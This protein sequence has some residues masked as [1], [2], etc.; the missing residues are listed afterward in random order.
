MLVLGDGVTRRRQMWSHSR[1]LLSVTHRHEVTGVGVTLSSDWRRGPELEPREV[2]ESAWSSGVKSL[3]S[4][5]CPSDPLQS[6]S[7]RLHPSEEFVQQPL[8]IEVNKK[9]H[10]RNGSISTFFTM[11]QV[12]IT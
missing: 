3:L 9:F 4:S 11:Y 8:L 7:K 5:Q 2:R 12:I 10:T 1:Q 6:Q